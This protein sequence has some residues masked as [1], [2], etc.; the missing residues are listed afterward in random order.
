MTYLPL[1][2]RLAI[3][4]GNWP[5]VGPARSAG[6]PREGKWS[7]WTEFGDSL[8]LPSAPSPC[9]SRQSSVHPPDRRPWVF[10]LDRGLRCRVL[11]WCK[12]WKGKDL[13]RRK[14]RH[15]CRSGVWIACGSFAAVIGR[16]KPCVVR[17]VLLAQRDRNMDGMP[18]RSHLRSWSEEGI[19][20]C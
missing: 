13:R 18:T 20:G 16:S 15:S 19:C 12:R 7:H 8:A 6:L 4:D 9:S 11:A 1:A 17:K 10:R 2:G 3:D 5:L 14:I